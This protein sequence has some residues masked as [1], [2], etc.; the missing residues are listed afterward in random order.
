V[1]FTSYERWI[2][3]SETNEFY[4]PKSIFECAEEVRKEIEQII[5]ND[6]SGTFDVIKFLKDKRNGESPT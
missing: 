5:D 4:Y 3:K 6:K 1:D 2:H